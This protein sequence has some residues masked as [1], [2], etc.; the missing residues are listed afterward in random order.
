MGSKIAKLKI[1][2][3]RGIEA[4]D[5]VA[6]EINLFAGENAQGKTGVLDA[7]AAA[8][9]GKCPPQAVRHDAERAE[10]LLELDDGVEIHRKIPVK[11]KQTVVVKKDNATLQSPQAFLDSLFSSE[12]LDPIGFIQ[13]KDR[14]KKLLEA[15]PV[16]TDPAEVLELLEGCGLTQADV[17]GLRTDSAHAFEVFEAVAKMLTGDRKG[18]NAKVKQATQWIKQER[19]DLEGAADPSEEI[20]ELTGQLAEV[21]AAAG[22][23]A[24]KTARLENLQAKRSGTAEALEAAH[25]RVA[26][27]EAQLA[28]ADTEIEQLDAMFKAAEEN[29]HGAAG[30]AKQLAEMQAQLAELL[31]SKGAW[32]ESQRRVGAIEV[33]EADLETLK[34][35]QAALNKGVKLFTKEAPAKALARTPL[36]VDGLEYKDGAFYVNNIHLDQLCGAETVRVAVQFTLQRVMVKGLHVVCVDGIERLGDKQREQFFS[37]LAEAGVQVWAT[38][39]DHGNGRGAPEGESVLYVVMQGGAPKDPQDATPAPEPIEKS[40]QGGLSF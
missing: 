33:K 19:A 38:E 28:E 14:Q 23:R 29:D 5:I 32:D 10:I 22:Q 35:R 11:G 24:E 26:D 9:V 3:W 2:N 21:K 8:A 27:L 7:I 20:A 37:E 15:L 16:T 1:R 25:Q 18:V 34:V 4:M 17:K 12:G 6:G 30:D 36:P 40:N 39:V 13:S 31:E